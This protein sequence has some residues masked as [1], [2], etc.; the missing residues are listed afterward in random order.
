[1]P[2]SNAPGDP[3][4][5][6][7]TG[8]DGL[9]GEVTSVAGAAEADVLVVPA[10]G[11]DGLELHTVS[12]TAAGVAVTPVLALDMTRPLPACAFPA[13]HRRGLLP[14]RRRRR[15]RRRCTPGGAAGLRAAR[16]RPM[17]FRHHARLRQ[18]PQ[19]V[20]SRDRVISGDQAPD[21]GPVAGGEL[22]GSRSPL[23]RRHLCAP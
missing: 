22:R 18:G 20:W 1:M 5:G 15:S 8:A 19:A 12:R 9:A 21:G 23:R 10:T 2:L 7:S 17:V 6:V 13:L 11:P 3:V 4:T 14:G 16:R